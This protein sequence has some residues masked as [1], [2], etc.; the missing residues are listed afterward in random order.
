MGAKHVCFTCRK[1]FNAPHGAVGPT[2]CPDCGQA[3][4]VVPHLFQ[5]PKKR[6][7]AKWEVVRYLV[8]HGFPYY[9]VR[10]TLAGG[11]YVKYPENMQEAKAFVVTYRAQA[12]ERRTPDSE[13]K[14]Q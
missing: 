6:E 13:A 8:D 2:K 12:L 1:A 10:E 9:H 11:G 4:A 5:P 14:S 3:L 7:A